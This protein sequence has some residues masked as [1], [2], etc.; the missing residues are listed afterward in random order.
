MHFK[1]FDSHLFRKE[2]LWTE[3]CD[4]AFKRNLKGVHSL[5][6]KYSG[7][8]ALPSAPRFMSMDEFVSLVQDGGVV[9]D[10]FGEREI[11]PIYSLS[12]MTQKDEVDSDRIQ[13]MV[14]V[15]FIEALGRVADRVS[16]PN[17]LDEGEDGSVRS[18]KTQRPLD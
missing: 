16:L 7:R 4:L 12:M 11:T 6:A 2:R 10:S 18:N 15:E 1:K 3:D 13:N 8:Y 17:L 5:Y 9:S 14:L